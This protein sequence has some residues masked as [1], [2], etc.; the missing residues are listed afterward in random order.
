M[1]RAAMERSVLKRKDR[2][3]LRKA[4]CG[5]PQCVVCHCE[6]VLDIQTRHQELADLDYHEQLKE[7]HEPWGN[8]YDWGEWSWQD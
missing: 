6:K 1:K 4:K 7:L 8:R 2:E 3:H 5:T